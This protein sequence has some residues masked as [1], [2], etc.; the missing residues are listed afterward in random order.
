[1]LDGLSP[2]HRHNPP[3]YQHLATNS[4]QA[5]ADMFP[6]VKYVLRV[7]FSVNSFG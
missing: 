2:L 4:A 7:L 3:S 1:M 6:E 5:L